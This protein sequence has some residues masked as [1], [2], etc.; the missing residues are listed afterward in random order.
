M[1]FPNGSTLVACDDGHARLKFAFKE[2]ALIRTLQFRSRVAPGI[3]SR[4]SHGS[5]TDQVFYTRTNPFTVSV[6][7]ACLNTQTSTY[8]FSDGNR[9]LIH[10]GLVN[11][12][13]AGQLVNLVT[14]LPVA[15]YYNFDH[16]VNQSTLN[17]KAASLR[18]PV[19]RHT[20]TDPAAL[21]QETR[22]VA[23]SVAAIWD[24]VLDDNGKRR[25]DRIHRGRVAVIDTGGRTTDVC[26]CDF[27]DRGVLTFGGTTGRDVGCLTVHDHAKA[28]IAKAFGTQ[29]HQI[30]DEEDFLITRRVW[31]WGQE[32]DVSVQID[33]AVQV[34]GAELVAFL[35]GV[36]GD[37]VSFSAIYLAGGGAHLFET[38]I[39]ARWRTAQLVEA[40]VFANCRGMLKMALAT[41]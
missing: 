37:G 13:L 23:Q 29:P 36:L 17:W 26:F 30:L 10:H 9:C 16:S 18:I 32:H 40:P 27:S 14:G 20:R 1:I 38:I 15:T 11:L 6:K 2:D 39:K 4:D 25:L 28:A 21:I 24:E 8:Q 12:G 41:L 33:E 19:Y 31:L 34:V 35:E 7:T 3:W 22:V 5:P